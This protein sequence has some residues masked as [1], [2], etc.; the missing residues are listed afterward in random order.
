MPDDFLELTPKEFYLA[1]KS[2]GDSRREM[3]RQHYEIARF[4]AGTIINYTSTILQHRISD[5]RKIAPFPWDEKDELPE[6]QTQ[7][8]LLKAGMRIAS[9]FGAKHS[10][11]KPGDP[12]TVL[13]RKWRK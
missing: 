3:V 7:E 13:A 11:R 6:A 8:Q 2:L 4:E 1:M 12:P 9:A 5:F 10:D